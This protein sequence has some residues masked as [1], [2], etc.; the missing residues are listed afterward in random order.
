MSVECSTRS[1]YICFFFFFIFFGIQY[2]CSN[3]SLGTWTKNTDCAPTHLWY[4][5]VAMNAKCLQ[6]NKLRHRMPMSCRNCKKTN[7][8]GEAN[9]T[10]KC[11][12]RKGKCT[13]RSGWYAHKWFREA[14]K[15]ET[16]K[17]KRD[18]IFTILLLSVY[19]NDAKQICISEQKT[20]ANSG[21]HLKWK[22]LT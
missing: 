19:T 21:T 13:I 4:Y 2:V 17:V 11:S 7:K 18:Y 8:K 9:W 20:H 10:P 5:Y 14:K 16:L 12:K 1:I 6:M 3:M 22:P 15:N